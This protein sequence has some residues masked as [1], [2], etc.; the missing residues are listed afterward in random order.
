ML[1]EKP[2][3]HNTKRLIQYPV[4]TPSSLNMRVRINN[5]ANAILTPIIPDIVSFL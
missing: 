1:A 4:A 5:K 2:S 3:T